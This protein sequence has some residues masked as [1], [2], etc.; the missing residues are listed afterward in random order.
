MKAAAAATAP[1]EAAEPGQVGSRFYIYIYIYLEGT[2]ILNLRSRGFRCSRARTQHIVKDRTKDCCRCN[3]GSA[4]RRAATELIH[5][6]TNPYGPVSVPRLYARNHTSTDYLLSGI[7]LPSGFAA[8]ITSRILV[9]LC[10][11]VSSNLSPPRESAD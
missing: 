9:F 4:S 11:H 7:F 1:E 3:S 2:S 5:E 6:A 10:L 8:T